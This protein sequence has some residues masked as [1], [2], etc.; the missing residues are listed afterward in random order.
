MLVK[1]HGRSLMLVLFFVIVAGSAG[2]SAM[3]RGPASSRP[4]CEAGN[5]IQAE[6]P[7]PRVDCTSLSAGMLDVFAHV[8]DDVK[9]M[10]ATVEAKVHAVSN[11]LY[12]F[13]DRVAQATP[14]N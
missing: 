9:T 6:V 8:V 11:D 2:A 13:I 4:G 14:A 1:D 12:D 5:S 3:S 10:H 7:D